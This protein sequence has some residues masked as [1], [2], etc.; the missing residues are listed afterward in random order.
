MAVLMAVTMTSLSFCKV[1]S[2]LPH[3][4]NGKVGAADLKALAQFTSPNIPEALGWGWWGCSC[5]TRTDRTWPFLLSCCCLGGRGAEQSPGEYE[6]WVRRPGQE[7]L[8][9]E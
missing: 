5:R 3:F 1:H 8:Y 7:Q 9:R 4:T 2:M 6:L